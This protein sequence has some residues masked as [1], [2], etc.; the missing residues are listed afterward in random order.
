M[1]SEAHVCLPGSCLSVLTV[2]VFLQWIPVSYSY[3]EM[4]VSWIPWCWSLVPSPQYYWEVKEPLGCGSKYIK[5]DCYCAL[6]GILPL[7]APPLSLTSSPWEVSG[8][9]FY[10]V[11]TETRPIDH[12]LKFLKLSLD[13]PSSLTIDLSQAYIITPRKL[14]NPVG[15]SYF[16]SVRCGVCAF[17]ILVSLPFL[18]SFFPLS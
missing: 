9:L 8:F 11:P 5:K 17:H 6:E 7:S 15:K 12:R 16:L 1:S 2:S 13:K 18:C 10:H 4:C 14:T 3:C